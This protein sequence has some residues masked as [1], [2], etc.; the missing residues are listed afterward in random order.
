MQRFCRRQFVLWSFFFALVPCFARG[1]T[2]GIRDYLQ[3]KEDSAFQPIGFLNRVEWPLLSGNQLCRCTWRP[4]TGE[5]LSVDFQFVGDSKRPI[6]YLAIHTPLYVSK[7]NTWVGFQIK[8]TFDAPGEFYP[9]MM[10][11]CVDPSGETHCSPLPTKLAGDWYVGKVDSAGNHWGG[12]GDGVLQ[13]PCRVESLLMD[14]VRDGWKISGRFDLLDFQF[15]N[16]IALKNDSM[17]SASVPDTSVPAN[18]FAPSNEPAELQIK[19]E[20]TKEYLQTPPKLMLARQVNGEIFP[21]QPVEA[22]NGVLSLPRLAERGFE[23]FRLTPILEDGARKI[24]GT[25]L[26]F[27]AAVLP[28][29]EP[30]NYWFGVSTHHQQKP[31]TLAARAGVGMIRDDIIWSFV[32]KEKGVYQ[33]P[34]A[35]DAYVDRA[36]ELGIEPLLI[37]LYSNPLYDDGDFPHSDEAVEAYARYAGKVVEHFKGRCRCYEVWNEWTGGCSMNRYLAGGSNTPENYLKLITAASREMRRADPEIVIVGGGGDH[38]TGHL[39][40]IEK[41]MKLGLM[42][43]CDAFSVHPYFYPSTPDGEQMRSKLLNIVRLMKENGAEEPKLWLTEHGWPTHS[44]LSRDRRLIESSFTLED[45]SA[46]MLVRSAVVSRSVPEVAAW[47]WY[48]MQNDGTNASYNEHNFGLVHNAEY[49]YQPKASVVALAFATEALRD[50]EVTED[51]ELS[52]ENRK[53]YSI[54]RDGAA[55]GRVAWTIQGTEDFLPPGTQKVVGLY[56]N[57]LLG[58]KRILSTRPTWFLA[59]E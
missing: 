22:Q 8:I 26:K 59:G 37:I 34:P 19:V 17:I 10:V 40:A 28:E 16:K 13:F 4:D 3:E 49:Q 55:V 39:A 57:E 2:P 1:E 15:F 21:D 25:P 58:E 41:M 31:L 42:K 14:R 43:Y 24:L 45:Y 47:F 20:P 30:L 32:E 36:R 52:N 6:E 53:V 38:Y 23:A 27:S 9:P 48:D 56:G 54:K 50:A 29:S 35:W 7:P 18:L 44:T 46:A 51:A 11:R 5:A 12:D 33:F